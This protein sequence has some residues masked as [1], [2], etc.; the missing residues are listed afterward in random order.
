MAAGKPVVACRSAAHPLVHR[1][2]GL[3]V[4]DNDAE[5]FAHAV[6]ELM[7]DPDLR[8]HLGHAA[9]ET[10]R[11]HHDPRRIAAQLEEV[12]VSAHERAQATERT[13]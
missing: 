1:E 3:A 6:I 8:R 12:M 11:E 5:A 4:D 9:R 13:R 2:N 10:A 7:G